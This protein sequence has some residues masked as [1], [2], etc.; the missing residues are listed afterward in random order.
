MG[1]ARELSR[2]W[3]LRDVRG[4]RD[5]AGLFPQALVAW[6]VDHPQLE[7]VFGAGG[8]STAAAVARAVS[9]PAIRVGA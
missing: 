8:V 3:I 4:C 2:R 5:L 7:D 1:S 9:H 6:G